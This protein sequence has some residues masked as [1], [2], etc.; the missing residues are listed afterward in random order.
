MVEGRH[1]TMGAQKRD[2]R[3]K[4]NYG[5]K[6]SSQTRWEK[7]Q[8]KGEIRDESVETKERGKNKN[9]GKG[10][11]GV[12]LLKYERSKLFLSGG[13]AGL[14]KANTKCLANTKSTK[15]KRSGG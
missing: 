15:K 6:E 3:K 11:S 10:T 7:L 13:T 5:R 4:K 2:R 8:R 1:A 9:N 12:G 14:G